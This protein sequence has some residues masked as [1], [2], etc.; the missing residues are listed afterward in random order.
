MSLRLLPLHVDLTGTL[1]LA[2][3]AIH[4]L[5]NEGF[6]AAAFLTQL[7][8]E[9]RSGAAFGA[10]IDLGEGPAGIVLWE[11]PG[12]L[13]LVVRLFALRP[14]EATAR[15]YGEC[16]SA[17]ARERGPLLL[18][19]GNL[20]G[21]KR[22]DL[23]PMFRSLGYLPFSRTEMAYPGDRGP[24]DES[25]PARAELRP[26]RASDEP[27]VV[28]VHAAAYSGRFDRYLF[29]TDLD[30]VRD[31][32]AGIRELVRG[33]WGTFLPWASMVAETDGRLVA[34]TVVVRASRGPLIA[35][36]ATDPDFA[37][38]GFGRAVVSASVRALLL[39]RA[40]AVHLVVTE[41]NRTAIRLYERIGFRRQSEPWDGW[42]DPRQLP[43]AAEQA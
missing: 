42:Y 13:G 20:P 32:E 19:P 18:L 31:A 41:G 39:R 26:M 28:R 37:R 40:E 23:L 24:P 6:D 3:D 38:R 27:S 16:I 4:R 30:P 33:R 21:P 17:L 5:P 25:T 12:P 34:L 22:E 2:R 15:R 10:L 14:P 7:E 36:V 29:L 43:V 1:A 35:D 8:T 9:V 11:R